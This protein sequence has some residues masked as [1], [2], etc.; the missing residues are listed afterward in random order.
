MST[1]TADGTGATAGT[2]TGTSTGTA[3]GTGRRRRLPWVVGGLLALVA[4]GLAAWLLLGPGREVVGAAPAPTVTVTAPVPT[5]TGV[6]A[7]RPAATA[8][9][10]VLPGTLRAHALVGSVADTT[11]PGQGAVEAWADTYDGGVAVRVGQWATPEEAAAVGDPL[12][13]ALVGAGGDGARSGDVPVADAAAGRWAVADGVA[14]DAAGT[15][16][17]TEGVSSA[18]WWNGTVVVV[19][20]APTAEVDAL[21][22]AYPL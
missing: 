4:A 3:T 16:V 17:P 15:P 7:E 11:W 13:G 22:A 6:P 5:S 9:T 14:V 10:A 2:S 8:L 20:V 18:A 1:G 12:V 19:L 21:W